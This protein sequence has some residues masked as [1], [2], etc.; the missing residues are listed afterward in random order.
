MVGGK[1]KNDELRRKRMKKRMKSDEKMDESGIL[2]Y[3][4]SY[5]YLSGLTTWHVTST[6]STDITGSSLVNTTKCDVYE[7]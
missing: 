3:S 7:K 4:Y 6:W 2:P 5:S 1:L